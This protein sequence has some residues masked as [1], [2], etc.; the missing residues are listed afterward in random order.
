[1]EIGISSKAF[2]DKKSMKCVTQEILFFFPFTLVKKALWSDLAVEFVSVSH[3]Y[4]HL[5]PFF[6]HG[7]KKKCF[8]W[9]STSPNLGLFFL[10]CLKTFSSFNLLFHKLIKSRAFFNINCSL[11]FSTYHTKKKTIIKYN[12]IA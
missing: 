5:S 12:M 3:H 9:R 7:A 8:L 6:F 10:I 4:Q 2:L 1:M 11:T